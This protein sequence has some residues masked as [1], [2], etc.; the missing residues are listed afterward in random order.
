MTTTAARVHRGFWKCSVA[1]SKPIVVISHADGSRMMVVE[2]GATHKAD[3]LPTRS[4][5]RH[6]ANW[7]AHSYGG[8][9]NACAAAYPAN[10]DQR[11]DLAALLHNTANDQPMIGGWKA[12]PLACGSG[13]TMVSAVGLS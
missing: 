5:K 7:L 1:R 10:R 11:N 12:N 8:P 3:K 13:T 4:C 2:P 9:H 6:R